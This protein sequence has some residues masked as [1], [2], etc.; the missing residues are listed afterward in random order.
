[1]TA[2]SE[3]IRTRGA[4]RTAATGELNP[5]AWLAWLVA[6]S[7]TAFL[8]SN[9]LYLSL[10]LIAVT[11]VHLAL[12]DTAK[13]RMMLP[14]IVIGLLFSLASVPFNVLTGSA[15]PTELASLPELRFPGWFGGASFGG[16]ITA[17]TLV[18]AAER[19]L[20]ISTLV[21]AAAAFNAAIDHFRLVRLA[22]RSLAQAMLV[23][24]VGIIVIPQAV[25]HARRVAEARRLRGRGQRGA[26]AL[27]ALLLPVL[28]GALER[29]VQRAESLEARGFGAGVRPA[30][31][32]LSIIGVAG[33]GIC[34]WGAFA[35]FYY[36]GGL[37]PPLLMAAGTA[38]IVLT[39]ARSG[40]G[41]QERLR[42]TPL[43][44]RDLAVIVAALASVSIV[45]GL[46]AAGTGDLSYLAYPAVSAP[47]FQPLA[48][49]AFVLLIAPAIGVT[50]SPDA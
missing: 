10:A 4:S 7:A 31:W 15:G 16:P 21:V 34:A 17:E 43:S 45:L 22:P 12:P 3:T 18:T 2:R 5:A 42:A 41:R 33:L 20:S 32:R 9:P 19:A 46:R 39:L 8:T 29:S 11:G 24:T 50:W 37:A 25:D 38:L 47:A 6:T 48:A 14:V 36:N 27:P 1:M 28:Q 49:S 30:D 23:L 40:A 13:K 26:R 44:A 35:Q